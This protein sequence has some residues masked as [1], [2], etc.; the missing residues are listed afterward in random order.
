MKAMDKDRTR[1]YATA[2]ELAD[3]IG[4]H[5]RH[6]PVI[7]TPPA[8]IYRLKKF[9][10]RNKGLVGAITIMFLFGTVSVAWV[11]E[12]RK[13]HAAELHRLNSEALQL[14]DAG[15]WEDAVLVFERVLAIDPTNLRG[16]GNY[17][18]LK[19]E[20]YNSL[21]TPDRAL[22]DD[23][24]E[25]LDQYIA[26]APA[27]AWAWNTRGVLLR[28]LGRFDDARQAYERTLELNPAN[29]AAWVNLGTLSALNRDLGAATRQ[30]QRATELAA[31]P[32]STLYSWRAL[33][34]LQLLKN[35]PRLVDSI[36][37]AR[38]ADKTDVAT[39]VILA[40][41]LLQQG[42]FDTALESAIHAD[43]LAEHTDAKAKRIWALAHL[44]L[45]EYMQAIECA[46]AALELGD[47]AT[48][49][50]LVLAV[51]EARLGDLA[52]AQA[53]L[54]AANTGWPPELMTKQ[55]FLP[56]AEKGV[57][58]FETGAELAS[59]RDLALAAIESCGS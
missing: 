50:Y 41:I 9:V 27:D 33:A 34:S 6:Q 12:N 3:D 18:I 44:S 1:R 24:I 31:E 51:A 49:G 4:R 59:L 55:S 19:K 56:S 45:G 37:R 36:E 32:V 46:R 43:Y 25:L 2:S 35:D 5:L 10:R 17:A 52:S 15:R 42:N 11:V 7:A 54:D 29:A 23:A 28:I 26:V 14:T 53:H 57:L 38:Q 20:Q 40:R 21:K 16:L 48:I 22:L 8:V 47:L 30:L 39:R 58:W 13:R